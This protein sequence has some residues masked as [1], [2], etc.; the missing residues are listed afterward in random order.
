[1][2]NNDLDFTLEEDTDLTAPE[3][4]EDLDETLG[5]PLET[6]EEAET[7]EKPV[8]KCS[9]KHRAILI[10]GI[11]LGVALAALIAALAA[12]HAKKKD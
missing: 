12:M 5:E 8:R 10:G 7:E 2:A 4:T 3:Q 1:M 9:N 6:E 11:A